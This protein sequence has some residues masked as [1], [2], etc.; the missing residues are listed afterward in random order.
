[1]TEII[2]DCQLEWD[3]R[4]GVLYVHNRGTGGTVL[5]ICGLDKSTHGSLANYGHMIDITHPDRVSYPYA[6]PEGVL[7]GT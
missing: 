2:E 4:R 5:R 1:M 6:V 3:K 7:N